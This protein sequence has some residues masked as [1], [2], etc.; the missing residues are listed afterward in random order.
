MKSAALARKEVTLITSQPNSPNG[1]EKY[2]VGM[3]S[4]LIEVSQIAN[5][6]IDSFVTLTDLRS[7][8][9][10]VKEIIKRINP[11][12]AVLSKFKAFSIDFFQ[13]VTNSFVFFQS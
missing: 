3:Q 4:P 8:A 2:A 1:I 11:M 10:K 13:S 7:T 6:L 12:T 5:R 9:P